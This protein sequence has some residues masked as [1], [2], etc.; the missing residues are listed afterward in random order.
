MV[1]NIGKR[2]NDKPEMIKKVRII[3]D[4]AYYF[5]SKI[6]YFKAFTVCGFIYNNDKYRVFFS[7]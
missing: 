6:L 5:L 1:G 4:F 2:L 3:K 7:F